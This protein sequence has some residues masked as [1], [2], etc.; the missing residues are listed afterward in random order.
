MLTLT[1]KLLVLANLLILG[2]GCAT[3]AASV[4]VYASSVQTDDVFPLLYEQKGKEPSIVICMQEKTFGDM[5]AGIEIEKS[6]CRLKAVRAEI[7]Q[8]AAEKQAKAV[9]EGAAS[10]EWRAV[11]G[12]VIGFVAGAF[13]AGAVAAGVAALVR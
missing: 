13:T 1:V 3:K 12:P 9:S 10:L 7:A 6:E 5:L 4:P 11:W 8:K 2:E